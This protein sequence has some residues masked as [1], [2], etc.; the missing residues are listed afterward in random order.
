MLFWGGN[1]FSKTVKAAL[2]NLLRGGGGKGLHDCLRLP[3]LLT[4]NTRQLEILVTTLPIEHKDGSIHRSE[5]V[6][7][8]SPVHVISVALIV[9]VVE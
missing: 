6:F 2:R 5:G 4:T 8:E 1:A 7:V 3:R 9:A